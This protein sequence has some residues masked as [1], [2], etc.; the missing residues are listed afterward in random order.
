MTPAPPIPKLEHFLPE[1]EFELEF[2][3]WLEMY[4]SIIIINI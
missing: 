4:S 2:S 3:S 1:L